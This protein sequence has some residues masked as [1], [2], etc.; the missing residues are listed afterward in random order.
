[1]SQ[2]TEQARRIY[3]VGH[4]NRSADELVEIL[5]RA[6]VQTLVDV[7]TAAGSRRNPQFMHD[8]MAVWLPEHGIEYVYEHDLGGFRKGS[9]ESVNTGWTH[10]AFRAYADYISTDAYATALAR[11]EARAEQ[12]PTCFMCAEAQWWRCHRR[13]ISDTLTVRGWDVLHL[14]LGREPRPHILTEFMVVKGGQVTYPSAE[15][16]ADG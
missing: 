15:T 14:G 2:P 10:P 8:A 13:I 3:T 4:S 12:H 9:P 6:G 5:D 7:R 16:P 11:L 1:M